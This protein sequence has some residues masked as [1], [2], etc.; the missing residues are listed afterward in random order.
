MT[1]PPDPNAGLR[2]A[3]TVALWVWIVLTLIP[4]VFIGG[5][6]L[7]CLFSGIM[8]AATAPHQ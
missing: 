7:L 1:L 2:Q 5:C 6:V 8:G 4:V 3:G